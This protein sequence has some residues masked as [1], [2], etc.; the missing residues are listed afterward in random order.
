MPSMVRKRELIDSGRDK[1][2]VRRNERGT[3]FVESDDFNRSPAA[4]RRSVPRPR[5][6]PAKVTKATGRGPNAKPPEKAARKPLVG[7]APLGSLSATKG[8]SFA[9]V[10]PDLIPF[11]T[12]LLAAD[13]PPNGPG[14][15]AGRLRHPSA[16]RAE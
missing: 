1:R 13:G 8:Q 6:D 12:C 14:D 16:E 10:P 15:Q 7:T 5:S 9:K 3:S 2:Y 4:D 11:A